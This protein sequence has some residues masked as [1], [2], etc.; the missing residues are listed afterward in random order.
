MIA[1]A[2]IADP[3]LRRAWLHAA[4]ATPTGSSLS[5]S[6][7]FFSMPRSCATR[8]WDFVTNRR[9]KRGCRDETNDFCPSASQ[10]VGQLASLLIPLY[11]DNLFLWG[12]PS[13]RS[14]PLSEH[15]TLDTSRI[16]PFVPREFIQNGHMHS[17]ARGWAKHDDSYHGRCTGQFGAL[18]T[19][20]RG[21]GGG[22]YQQARSQ[23]EG[24][25]TEAMIG[26]KGCDAEQLKKFC[27]MSTRY[28]T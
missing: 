20:G 25:R 14:S 28:D 3:L 12:S 18:G 9:G 8:L 10:I 19:D 27:R 16:F 21:G 5:P 24:L 15:S 22:R 2:A 23:I 13:I 7:Y 26:H 1:S 17:D 6:M 4:L 11:A